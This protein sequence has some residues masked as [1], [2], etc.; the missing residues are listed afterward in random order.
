MRSLVTVVLVFLLSPAVAAG[1][2]VLE[3][4]GP[5]MPVN[6]LKERCIEFSEV[7][8]GPD[9]ADA[10]DCRVSDSGIIGMVEGKTY[11]YALYCLIPNWAVAKGK[12]DAGS[13]SFNAR[14]YSHQAVAI[15]V[16]ENA[17][18]SVRLAYEQSSLEL[19]MY[20]YEKPTLLHN[21][22]G[23]ILH[24]HT[25]LTGTGHGN[26]S[27]Y[28]LHDPRGWH[29]IDSESWLKD[30]NARL[31]AGREV[32]KGVWPDLATLSASVWLYKKG[33]GNC[34]PSGGEA[35]VSLALENERI[36]IKDI[37]FFLDKKWPAE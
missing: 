2:A 15:F 32:W 14:L 20:H 3:P 6:Q 1:K 5:D 36:A 16:K 4:D 31:P 35:R 30:L 28:F 19:G 24:V 13:D 17:A 25:E 33:D 34:C 22:S 26:A 29:R 12:C 10:G 23:V 11:Y 8:V 21:A 37:Q 9:E 7:K 18:D 27:Q